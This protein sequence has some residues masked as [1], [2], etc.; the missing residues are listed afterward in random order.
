MNAATE[1]ISQ[2]L[3]N[4]REPSDWATVRQISDEYVCFTESAIRQ[5]IFKSNHNGLSPY[6]RRIGRKVLVSRQGFAL[7]LEGHEQK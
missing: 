6:V 1:N 2:H 4:T 5:L 7:W 3:Q